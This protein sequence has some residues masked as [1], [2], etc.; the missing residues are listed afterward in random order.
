M[1]WNRDAAVDFLKMVVAGQIDQAYA[2]Y[3]DMKG[4]H[5][6][7]F[8][9]A[10]MPAL[11][12]GMMENETQFPGKKL[13]VLRVLED[14]N[15]VSV[16]SRLSLKNGAMVLAVNHSMRFDG[17]KIVELWDYAQPVTK[18]LVNQDGLF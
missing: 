7:V 9:P 5:H 1:G 3:V 13:E 10:G 6:N 8:T 11:K 16:Y 17:G 4:K 12:K 14:G 2:K 18:E 15:L